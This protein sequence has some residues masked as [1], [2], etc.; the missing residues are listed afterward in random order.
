SDTE[1]ADIARESQ[2]LSDMP[3]EELAEL[4]AIWRERGLSPETAQLVAQELT[5]HDALAAHVRDELGLSEVHTANPLQAAFASGMTFTLAASLPLIA[6]WFAPEG[7]IVAT[8]LVVTLMALALLGAAGARTGGAPMG[9]A[10]GRV[11]IWGVFAMAVT[12]G[13]GRL[14]GVAIS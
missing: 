2:A 1:R 13:I 10:I 4:V 9:R 3:E 8:V 12:W 11:V 14:F 5:A 6:A 7:A